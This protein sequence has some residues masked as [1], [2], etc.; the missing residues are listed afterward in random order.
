VYGTPSYHVQKLFSLNK[1]TKVIPLQS[2]NDVLA[3]QDSLYA[4]AVFDAGKREVIIKIVNAKPQPESLNVEWPGIK[5]NAKEATV[6][7]MAYDNDLLS[8]S[9]DNPFAVAPLE[10]SLPVKAK[11]TV[12]NMPGYSFSVIKIP[13]K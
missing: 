3:G 2:N 4:S 13:V 9:L 1:G 11:G 12:Y 8:N 5:L 10:S 7:V 6:L